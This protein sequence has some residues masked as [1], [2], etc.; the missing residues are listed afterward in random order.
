MKSVRLFQ[1]S[2]AMSQILVQKL[3]ALMH[4]APLLRSPKSSLQKAAVSLL[5]NIGRTNGL[6]A[7]MGEKRHMLMQH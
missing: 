5:G 3:G 7:T 1:G 2:S 4:I 6:Q